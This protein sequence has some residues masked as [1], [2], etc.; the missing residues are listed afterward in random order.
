MLSARTLDS[1]KRA[2]K[3]VDR[4]KDG[5]RELKARGEEV[6]E[7]LREFMKYRRGLRF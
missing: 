5:G 3:S 6:L 2:V 1:V 7:N 4:K